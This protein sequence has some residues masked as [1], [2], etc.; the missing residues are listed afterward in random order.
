MISICVHIYNYYAY[1]LVRRLTTQIEQMKAEEEFEIVCIDDCSKGYYLNQNTGIVDI[2]KYL[3]LKEHVGKGRTMGL[4]PK[5]TSGEW[6]LF[7]D[8]DSKLP[9]QFL[10]TYM[11]YVDKKVGAV[12]GGAIYDPRDNDH[13][14]RLCYRYGTKVECR[15]VAER[16][17]HPYQLFNARNFMIRRE[18]F[19]KV[20]VD[21]RM[22]RYGHLSLM[23]GYRLQMN[24][25]PTLHVDNPV[26]VGYV[27][28]N[29][30]YLNKTVEEVENLVKIYNEMWEDQRFCRQERIISS[31]AR[32]RRMGLC[33]IYYRLFGMT[34]ALVESQ[35]VGGTTV[36]LKIFRRYKLWHFIQAARY[37]DKKKEL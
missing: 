6:L 23:L 36:S 10:K 2:A 9:D 5:Y 37:P 22:G 17:K 24:H 25:I 16:A 29:A 1:P 3:R 4:F 7:V 33:G 8:A 20:K 12:V 13:E 31:Y 26:T 35:L 15:P 18:T 11:Q 30:E 34:K 32:L 28:S 27:E 19:E 21:P 14:H